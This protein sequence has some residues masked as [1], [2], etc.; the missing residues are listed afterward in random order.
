MKFNIPYV[1]ENKDKINK[2]MKQKYKI[3]TGDPGKQN[4]LVLYNPKD[5]KIRFTQ[6]NLKYGK[7]LKK[8]FKYYVNN[9]ILK[10]GRRCILIIGDTGCN[11][12]NKKL[13]EYL[14]TRFNV[15]I[16]N[17]YRTSKECNACKSDLSFVNVKGKRLNRVVQ[18]TNENCRIILNKDVNACKN[19]FKRFLNELQDHKY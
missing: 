10:F 13:V 19:I 1:Y 4:L 11:E 7:S 15:F 18:C 14:S 17:E 9:L 12:I 2:L 16:V 8:S 5:G 3:L 6:N